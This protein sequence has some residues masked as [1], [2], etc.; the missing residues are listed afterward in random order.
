MIGSKESKVISERWFHWSGTIMWLSQREEV[1]HILKWNAGTQGGMWGITEHTGPEKPGGVNSKAQ[2]RENSS[3]EEDISEMSLVPKHTYICDWRYEMG[4]PCRWLLLCVNRK[5][6]DILRITVD[7]SWNG[8][9][10][11][12]QLKYICG[13]KEG[14]QSEKIVS[15]IHIQS[16]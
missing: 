8:E 14:G 7:I 15:K 11:I 4:T 13:E 16:K 9:L 2:G 3:I 5:S 6:D 12:L 10:K 1:R